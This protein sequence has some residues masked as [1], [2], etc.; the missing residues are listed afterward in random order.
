MKKCLFLFGAIFFF[1]LSFV[2]PRY[3]IQF[4]VVTL[5]LGIRWAFESD[6]GHTLIMVLDSWRHHSHDKDEEISHR[7]KNHF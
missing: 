3:F 2:I 4:L 1:I 5:I 6:G 7:F